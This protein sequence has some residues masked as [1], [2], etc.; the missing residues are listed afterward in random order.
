MRT[1]ADH[2]MWRCRSCVCIEDGCGPFFEL[3]RLRLSLSC[4]EEQSVLLENYRNGIA[5]G[6]APSFIHRQQTLVHWLSFCVVALDPVQVCQI[7]QG[8]LDTPE[9]LLLCLFKRIH[10]ELHRL[11]ILALSCRLPAG[12]CVYVPQVFRKASPLSNTMLLIRTLEINP[13]AL[14]SRTP[15]AGDDEGGG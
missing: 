10:E 1:N 5:S 12:F 9:A 11:R 8:A 2:L 13:I 15:A 6:A 4:F 3:L 14:R 7:L